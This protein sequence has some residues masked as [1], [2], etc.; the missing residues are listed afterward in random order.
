MSGVKACTVIKA[1]ARSGWSLGYSCALGRQY[2]AGFTAKVRQEFEQKHCSCQKKLHV[3]DSVSQI[4]PG[5]ESACE[6][7]RLPASR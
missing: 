1:L 7:E 4:T 3:Q 5:S 2:S 6:M